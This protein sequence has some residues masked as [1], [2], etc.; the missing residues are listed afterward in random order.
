MSRSG[1]G[2]R[3]PLGSLST[4]GWGC[5]PAQLVVWREVSQ[6]W[7]LQ[8]VG[9]V[10]VLVLMTQ[11]RYHPTGEHMHMN[12]PQYVRHQLLCPQREPQPPPSSPG[13]PPRPAGMSVPGSVKLLL[14]LLVPL[15]VRF[16]YTFNSEICFPQSCGAPEIKPHWSSKPN[17]LGAPLPSTRSPGWGANMKLRTLTPVGKPLHYNHSPVCGSP[18]PGVWDLIISPVLSY[19]GFFV[20]SLVVEVF[21]FFFFW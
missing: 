7:S 17:A 1:C 18:T 14:L 2:L 10:Q 9:W 19:C 11:A 8:A 15:S 21:F 12:T 20:M 3:K 4:D 16:L 5:V 6:H 13:D